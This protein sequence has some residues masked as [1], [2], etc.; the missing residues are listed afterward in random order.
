M[1]TVVRRNER[2]WAIELITKINSIVTN[3]D[4]VIKKAGGESTVS[5]SRGNNMF[6]DVILYGNEEQS[7]I[8]QGWELKMPDVPIE[9]IAFIKDAQRKANALGLNSCLIWNFTYAVLY[10][11]DAEGNFN[12]AKQW[13]ETSFIKSREDVNTYRKEWEL[14]LEKILLDVNAYFLDGNFRENLIENIISTMTLTTIIK[15]N[16][17][18]VANLLRASAV[19][20]AVIFS[21]IDNWW[22]AVKMEYEHDETDMYAAYAKSV[23]LNWTNRI[24]FAHIMKS[25]HNTARIIDDLTYGVTPDKANTL[26]ETITSKCDFFN[27]FLP[28]KHGEILPKLTWQDLVE[29]AI[30]LKE[31]GISRL[32]QKTLQNIL[33]GSVNVVRRELNGQF[34]TPYELAHILVRLTVVDWTDNF[35]DCC[36]GTGTIAKAALDIKKDKIGNKDAVATV[37]A[38][39]KYSYPLQV[40][41]ISMTSA[42]TINLPNR[43]FRQNALKTLPSDVVHITNPKDG[44]DLA[45][46][47]PVM[48]AIVS[49]LPFVEF[50]KLPVDD[51]DVILNMIDDYELD[52]RSDLYFYI[53][54]KIADMLKPDGR[55]GIITSNSWLGTGAGSKFIGALKLRYDILQIH[56]SGKGRWFKNADVVTTLIVMKK[57]GIKSINE[58]AFF[59][60]KKS[61]EDF[62]ASKDAEDSLVNSAFLNQEM[63]SSVCK[64][65][66]YKNETIVHTMLSFMASIGFAR[67]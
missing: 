62:V 9:D 29:Y 35:L 54:I 67:W 36:C 24:T 32:D 7:V 34:T 6:P 44:K 37:W 38:S 52:A 20:N 22:K 56:I 23:I 16:Q 59:L 26:F 46:S 31:N 63:D 4:W 12:V 19:K 8:L 13:D 14:L 49:N 2:S 11:K 27:V 47:L 17:V 10:F 61:L 40:A 30:F 48:G 5:V 60:W 33:E 21:Y 43:L 45:F 15:R 58:V 39:D 65:S 50:E 53:A 64:M 51:L 42:D 25:Y 28:M 66:V 41:N 57:K 55:I 18:L 1:S 3:R